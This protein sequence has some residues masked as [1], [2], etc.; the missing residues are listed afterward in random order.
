MLFSSFA[1]PV[2]IDMQFG[3]VGREVR[4]L[5]VEAGAED[6]QSDG[7]EVQLAQAVLQSGDGVRDLADNLMLIQIEPQFDARVLQV[8]ITTAGK[9][10]IGTK[11][12]RKRRAYNEH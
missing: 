4:I 7:I 11:P 9:G 5:A 2:E 8:I 6:R 12:H 3:V 10:L 1:L